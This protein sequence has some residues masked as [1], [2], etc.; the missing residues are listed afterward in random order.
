[1]KAGSL[2][3][4]ALATMFLAANAN[5]SLVLYSNLANPNPLNSVPINNTNW[6]AMSFMT[7]N[8]NYTLADIVL[9]LEGVTGG[10][11]VTPRIY[12]SASNSPNAPVLTLGTITQGL[13]NPASF[14]QITLLGGN[15]ALTANT[16][17]FVVLSGVS[18]TQ[19]DAFWEKEN[20]TAAT[21]ITGAVAGIVGTSP[22]G[23]ATWNLDG[24]NTD[25]Q[26]LVLQVDVNTTAPEP[27]TIFG[28]IAG[29]ALMLAA[30]MG[31]R[32]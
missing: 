31:R 3:F 5:A 28:A 4:L 11:A 23:G 22:N 27:G 6:A 10:G 12:S 32:V 30:K 26:P 8:N 15:F 24:V 9:S 7:D 14:T 25:H 2:S 20:G 17:Y 13:L 29:L 1:M 21:G 19:N 16:L 18:T